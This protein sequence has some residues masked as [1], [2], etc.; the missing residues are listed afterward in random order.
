MLINMFLIC[1]F[2]VEMWIQTDR[3]NAW[4][5]R[6]RQVTPCRHSGEDTSHACAT[7][8]GITRPGDVIA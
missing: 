8:N 4:K 6:P 7:T 5:P 2:M 1:F 3:I